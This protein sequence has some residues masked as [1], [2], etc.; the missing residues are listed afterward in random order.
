MRHQPRQNQ[1]ARL[2]LRLSRRIPISTAQGPNKMYRLRKA[3]F[4]HYS[5]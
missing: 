4:G 3:M 5:S 2:R 1:E